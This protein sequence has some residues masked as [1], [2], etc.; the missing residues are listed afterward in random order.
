MKKQPRPYTKTAISYSSIH[1]TILKMLLDNE[2]YGLIHDN[3][4]DILQ[5]RERINFRDLI[6]SNAQFLIA[7]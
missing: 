2:N 1:L 3:K 7:Q 6:N 5:R 4:N